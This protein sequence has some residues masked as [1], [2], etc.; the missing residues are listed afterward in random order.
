LAGPLTPL[1][2][3]IVTVQPRRWPRAKRQRRKSTVFPLQ[4]WGGHPPRGAFFRQ[5]LLQCNI[6]PERLGPAFFSFLARI[7]KRDEA[8]ASARRPAQAASPASL[9]LSA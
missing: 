4:W 2:G 1:Y 9:A 8:G 3:M 5:L 6:E 7:R